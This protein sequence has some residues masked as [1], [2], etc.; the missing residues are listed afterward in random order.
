MTT[1]TNAP[2][3]ND[4]KNRANCAAPL[5]PPRS[6]NSKKTRKLSRQTFAQGSASG[7]RMSLKD[8]C[9]QISRRR[10]KVQLAIDAEYAPGGANSAFRKQ[11][12]LQGDRAM[13]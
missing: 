6:I 3:G 11:F 10:R 12:G 4:P 9:A 8:Q 5:T 2:S 7:A 13:S 1:S